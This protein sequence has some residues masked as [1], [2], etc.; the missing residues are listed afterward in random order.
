MG[1]L[2]AAMVPGPRS[3]EMAAH[4]I[5][6]ERIE[7]ASPSLITTVAIFVSKG[8]ALSAGPVNQTHVQMG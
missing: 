3:V 4:A 7:N 8:F 1:I 6:A 2:A 5:A